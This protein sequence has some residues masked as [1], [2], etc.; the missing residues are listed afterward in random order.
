MCTQK[1]NQTVRLIAE[2]KLSIL[3]YRQSVKVRECL[4]YPE[5]TASILSTSGI[6]QIKESKCSQP[7]RPAYM[8]TL[9][10]TTK[11]KMVTPCTDHS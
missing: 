1:Y 5:Q 9:T 11:G 2:M 4:Q 10:E 3:L 7:G 8:G 6:K